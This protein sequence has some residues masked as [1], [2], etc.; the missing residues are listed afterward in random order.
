MLIAV[1]S[2]YPPHLFGFT[3]VRA[4]HAAVTN[5]TLAKLEVLNKS[6]ETCIKQLEECNKSLD[7]IEA[8]L[9]EKEESRVGQEKC[10]GEKTDGM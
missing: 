3:I 4:R 9:L 5:A 6:N 8:R 1:H 2:R 7:R 10:L